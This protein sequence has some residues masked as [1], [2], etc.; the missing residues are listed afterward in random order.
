MINESAFFMSRLETISKTGKELS[1][2][3]NYEILKN[4]GESK[5]CL[6]ED[7]IIRG[8][9]SPNTGLLRRSLAK[10]KE[11]TSS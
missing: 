4:D 11:K 9:P 5:L 8:K 10:T 2:T 3:L 7:V 1:G 6:C